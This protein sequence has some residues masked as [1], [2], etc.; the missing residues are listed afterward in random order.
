MADKKPKDIRT[1]RDLI[2]WQKGMDLAESVYRATEVFPDREKYGLT[3]QMRRAAVSVPSNVAEGFG[4]GRPAEF[5]RFIEITR[6][7]LFELQT[8]CE[9]ARRMRWLKG[10]DL[11]LLRDTAKEVDRISSALLRSLKRRA[12]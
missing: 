12:V 7:S 5:I 10:D 11:N 6:G 2:V 4:R 1:H 9:L 8:Q 3:A